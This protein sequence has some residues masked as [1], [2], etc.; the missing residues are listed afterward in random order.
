MV[1]FSC[2][3]CCEILK[4][5]K[6]DAHAQRCRGAQFTCIDCN[7]TFEGTSYRAHTSCVT[8]EQ[9][10]HKSVYKAPK[11]KGKNAQQ[12]QA[13]P[14]PAAV[15]PA[16][17]TSST[18]VP[19]SAPAAVAATN[20]TAAAEKEGSKKRSRAEDEAAAAAAPLEAGA[21]SEEQPEQKKK[22]KEK[23]DKKDKKSKSA[24]RGTEGDEAP[25]AA[26]GKDKDQ[27]KEKEKE[28]LP[29]FLTRTVQPLLKSDSD[30][31][32][33]AQLRDRVV[34]AAREAGYADAG[35]VEGRLFEGLKV[36]GKKGKVR[37]EFLVRGSEGG[38]GA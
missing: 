10:Y 25:V 15:A 16:V 38:S 12:Q 8:E 32:S 28:P 35:E 17:S 4:K 30:A 21:P 31:P 2:E 27:Q 29:V 36:G 3:S 1:S 33:L 14:A 19:A 23:K 34:A 20:A 7:T 11:G 6:L 24:E 37:I 18:P 22:K 26:A 9:R 13:V 5:P